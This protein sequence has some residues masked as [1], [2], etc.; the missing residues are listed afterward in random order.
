MT[1]MRNDNI[2]TKSLNFASEHADKI[3]FLDQCVLNHIFHDN[4]KFVNIRY[5]FQYK[6]NVSKKIKNP[7]IIHFVGKEKP[8]FGYAHPYE[9]LYYHYLKLTPFR[10]NFVKFKQRMW[11]MF[12]PK[13]IKRIFIIQ[14]CML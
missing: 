4:I 7:A 5:N 13:F 11:K 12:Y 9:N 8:Y 10:V 2:V 14:M 1:K 3:R 6:L